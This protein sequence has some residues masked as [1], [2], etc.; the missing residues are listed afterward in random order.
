MTPQK[1]PIRA[2]TILIG[3]AFAA[4]AN[5][6][7]SQD[8]DSFGRSEVL[9]DPERD[10]VFVDYSLVDATDDHFLGLIGVAQAGRPAAFRFSPD[11][12][13]LFLVETFYTRGNRGERTDTVTIF[14]TATLG[15]AGEVVIPPKRALLLVVEGTLALTD[16]G[17][18]LGV[19][20][21]TPATSISVVDIESKSFVGEIS[22]PGCSLVFS[23]GDRSYM[24]ICA[25]GDLLTV[26][27]DED[28]REVSKERTERFFDPETD[29]IREPGVR[30][31]D[32]WLFVSFDGYLHT[33]DISGD[34]P[35]VGESG[36]LLTASDR[37]QNWRIAGRQPLTV[38]QQS[39]RLYV[40]ARQNDEPLD[41]PADV[42]GTEIWS[43]DLA[44]RERLQRLE[45]R[46]ESAESGGAGAT[47][48]STS[49]DGASNILVTQGDDPLLVSAGGT[50]ISVRHA[51]TGEYLHERLQHAPSSGW[52]ALRMR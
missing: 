50:G 5:I 2:F 37:E 45:A 38:H 8:F 24:M 20:N 21:L 22:T 33:V 26:T 1:H 27:L 9:P 25:N 7:A 10:W 40:L 23:A 46:P 31:G 12:S 51:L 52:L 4:A 18:F 14:D 19:F 13:S 32:E 47:L 16:N 49:G 15:V 17:R 41:D 39:G 11:G 28:G 35:R 44:S 42:D 30:Y 43:F 36:S 3:L 29:P 6:C 34:M 48:G